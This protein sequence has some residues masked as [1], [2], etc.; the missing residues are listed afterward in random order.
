M[1]DEIIYSGIGDLSLAAALSAEYILLAADR[2]A[3][4]NH[5]ALQYVGDISVG[6]HSAVIKCPHV[7]LMGYALLASTGD[8]TSVANTALTDGSTSVTVGRYSKA[9]EASDLAKMTAGAG[10]LSAQVFA[11][12]AMVSGA[13]TLTSLVANLMDNFTTVVGSTG[14][15]MTVANF[16]DAITALEVQNAQGPLLT[17]LHSQQFGDFRKDLGINSGGAVQFAPASAEMI[18]V[19][20]GGLVGSFAG[21]DIVVSNYV[22]DMNGGLDRGGGMFAKGAILWA[23]GSVGSDGSPDQMVIGGK[24]LFE[25]DRTARSGLTAYVSHR[26]LGVAEGIDGFGVTIQTDA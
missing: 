9:Y 17:V 25:R 24:V 8:G 6:A 23:D 19:S 2:N 22:P 11:M 12:D 26:Y 16:L 7:G 4:P 21:V 1:A 14:V 5:P 20:G 10:G 13:L 18:K 15:D 3:L